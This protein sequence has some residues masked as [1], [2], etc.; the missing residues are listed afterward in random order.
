MLATMVA[1]SSSVSIH[2]AAAIAR[3]HYG[4]EIVAERLTGERDENFRLRSD[5]ADFVMKIASAAEEPVVTDLSTAALLHVERA[6]SDLPC[7]RVRLSRTGS[8]Q[9]RFRDDTGQ[10]R[11]GRVLSWLPGVPLR[12]VTSSAAQRNACA[13][14]AARIGRALRNFDHPAARRRLIWDLRLLPRILPLLDEIPDFPRKSRVAARIDEFRVH[15]LPRLA[16][17]R[18]QVIHND[19]NDRNIL[20]DPTDPSV[21]AGVIDYG[22]MI[23]SALVSDLAILAAEQITDWETLDET[24]GALVAAYQEVEPLSAAELS[25]LR[26]LIG[27]RILMS[28]VIPSWHRCR[29]PS[30]G[31]YTRVTPDF[32]LGRLDIAEGLFARESGP[33]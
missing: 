21:I 23:H 26:L 10:M 6:D 2:F 9:V 32:V 3:E 24:I 19:L 31:H 4:L 18:Q 11:T 27:A 17:L 5:G 7:P 30:S 25:I 15:A 16:T 13:R 20:V 33:R 12:S 8:T 1:T 14:L 22:D 28:A 29:N